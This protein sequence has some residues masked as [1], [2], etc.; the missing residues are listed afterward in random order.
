MPEHT[1]NTYSSYIGKIYYLRHSLDS[2]PRMIYNVNKSG[3]NEIL[4][5]VWI[6]KSDKR[7]AQ[8]AYVISS[9][10]DIIWPTINNMDRYG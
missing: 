7:I 10:D 9:A 3:N 4:F 5:H 2:G 6:M 8:N 1:V